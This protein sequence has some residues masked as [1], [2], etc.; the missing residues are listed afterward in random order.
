M[1]RPGVHARTLGLSLSRLALSC[2]AVAC[3][4]APPRPPPEIDV[5]RA[6]KSETFA[7]CVLASPLL[8]PDRDQVIVASGDGSVVAL[9]P[10]SGAIAWRLALPAPEGEL[11]HV[12]ATPALIGGDRMVIAWQDVLAASPDPAAAP[13]S[14]HHVAMIDLARGAIDPAFPILT[15][16]GS[17]PDADGGTVEFAASNALSRSRLIHTA[18]A[19]HELGLVYVSFGNARDIQPWH[20]WIFELDLDAWRAGAE[21]ISALLL[22]T[23]ESAC[24]RPGESGSD[25]MICGGGVWAPA[26]PLLVPGDA[27]SYQLII[28]T[29]NGALDL[30]RGSYSHTLM[31]VHGP[32]LRFDPRCDPVACAGFDVLAPSTACMESCEDLFVPRLG[33]GDPPLGAPGCEA[34][35]F[36]ECYAA[37]DWDLGANAPARVELEDGRAVLVLP[38]K[39]GAVYLIDAD[40]LGT[41]HDRHEVI[42]PCGADGARCDA[43]WAGSMVT[44]PEITELDGDPIAVIATFLPDDLHPAGLVALRIVIRDGAPRLERVWEAPSFESPDA[45]A[46]FRRHPSA[47]RMIEIA[48]VAHA[49]VVDQGRAGVI[50]G[51][52]QV[53]RVLDGEIVAR[54]ALDGPG[55]RF[56]Q[57][58]ALGERLFLASCENGNA[59]PSHIEAWDLRPLP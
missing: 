26:G 23:P 37:L 20:G 44:Q 57:P 53:T 39:D 19:G 58:L 11:A 24:G 50:A 42:A 52:L 18:A 27:G 16:A 36:F 15:L 21:T 45:R 46:W 47:V 6:W 33:A 7:G 32:G 48:G 40:H 34:L 35:S 3:D 17:R 25:D 13:R 2:L 38:A 41:L 10:D 31:R 51:Q 9:A 56:A 8:G 54:V 43:N 55:Q 12:I 30:A 49:V 4:P 28:P 14:A 59:G 22:T 1:T 29:G 5:S